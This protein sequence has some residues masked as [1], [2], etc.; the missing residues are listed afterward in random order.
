MIEATRTMFSEY[1]LPSYFWIEVINTIYYVQNKI[2]INKFH[3]KTPHELYYNKS[4]SIIYFK[5]FIFKIYILNTKDNLLNFLDKIDEGIFI[6]YSTT[7]RDYR[8][9]NKR[10]LRIKETLDVF[11]EDNPI[12]IQ[13]Y[14]KF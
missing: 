3:K 11:D 10:T 5:V 2:H 9:Y 6:D 12:K 7:N 1:T 13:T 14:Q 8:I 4:S